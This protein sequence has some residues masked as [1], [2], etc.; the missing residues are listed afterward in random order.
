MCNVPT[1]LGG[2]CVRARREGGVGALM[3]VLESGCFLKSEGGE[4]R[5]QR[6]VSQ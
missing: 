5:M 4:E 3:D 2:G 6:D 1:V